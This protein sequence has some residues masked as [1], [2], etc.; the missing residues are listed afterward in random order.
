MFNL[1]VAE[2]LRHLGICVFDCILE[3]VLN[4]LFGFNELTV[5]LLFVFIN[6]LLLLV[7]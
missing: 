2:I 5:N 3:R 6:E 7:F 1:L 4:S